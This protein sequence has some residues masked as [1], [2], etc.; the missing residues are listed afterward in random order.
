MTSS[1]ISLL[2]ADILAAEDEAAIVDLL[3]RDANTIAELP[4]RE[5]ERANERIAD[6]I[7]EHREVQRDLSFA[8]C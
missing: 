1:Q 3:V 5:R 7:R 8:R 6:A 2:I 4:P